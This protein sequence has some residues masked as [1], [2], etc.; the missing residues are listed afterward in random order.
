M[1]IVSSSFQWMLLVFLMLV[2]ESVLTVMFLVHQQSAL[3]QL[4]VS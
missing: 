4:T 1:M 2:S 3:A